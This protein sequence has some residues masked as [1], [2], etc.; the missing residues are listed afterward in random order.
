MY[1]FIWANLP[2]SMCP[3]LPQ[4]FNAL[5]FLLP[6]KNT[7]GKKPTKPRKLNWLSNVKSSKFKNPIGIKSITLASYPCCYVVLH[8]YSIY[9]HYFAFISFLAILDYSVTLAPMLGALRAGR[10]LHSKLLENI[11]RLPLKFFDTTPVGRIISRFSNDFESLDTELPEI[12]DSFVWCIFEV[13][14]KK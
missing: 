1:T 12:L 3:N 9:R 14:K 2:F 11:M 10:H 4:N 7:Y 5:Y 6:L 13:N 8:F